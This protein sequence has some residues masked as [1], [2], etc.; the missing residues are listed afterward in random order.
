MGAVGALVC[1]A[2]SNVILG[3]SLWTEPGAAHLLCQGVKMA[4]EIPQGTGPMPVWHTDE[5]LLW[6]DP[7]HRWQAAAQ[8]SVSPDVLDSG[9]LSIWDCLSHL[10]GGQDGGC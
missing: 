5:P 2:P 3:L 7:G 10:T 8:R 9:Y 4:A 6:P 1:P